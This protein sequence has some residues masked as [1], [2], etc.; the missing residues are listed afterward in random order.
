MLYTEC[1]QDILD[2]YGLK[3]EWS[4]KSKMMGRPPLVSAKVLVDEL[5]LPMTAEEFHSTLYGS[6]MEKFPDAKLLPGESCL[7][8]LS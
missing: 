6:L 3:F 5:N 4:V 7:A 2:K 1:T 8:S